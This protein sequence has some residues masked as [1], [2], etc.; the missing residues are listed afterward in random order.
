[1]SST[2]H[3]LR[4]GT[5]GSL[6]ARAQSQQVADALSLLHPGL[7]VDIV[8]I[9]TS[10]DAIVDRPLQELGGKGLFTK[11]LELALL[12][13]QIDFAVHSF[14][15]VPVTM[16]LI[17]TSELVIAAVPPRENPADVLVSLAAGS[18][19][20]LP[21]GS[22]VGTSSA[23]RRCQVLAIRPDVTVLPIR[24]NIDTRLG[25]LR[26]GEFD[27]ILLARA[28]VERAGLFDAAIMN[29][30]PEQQMLCAP[31]QGALALQC[32]RSDA[33]TR[34]L[35][36]AVEGPTTRLCV[37]AERAIVQGLQGDCHSPIAA[38]ATIQ[39]QRCTLHAR[40]GGR[41]GVPPV[42]SATATSSKDAPHVA[43]TR[44]LAELRSQGASRL[45][46]G[47]E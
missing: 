38:L 1:M 13:D 8:T 26:R 17:D 3:T 32:R 30:I 27:A 42:I 12:R 33:V 21:P 6:L 43:V 41:D 18:L 25:K 11:E 23:R 29:E 10:G 35:L 22:R 46:R 47:I 34:E 44:V 37:E 39:R 4:L 2:P 28:G 31:G 20:Q 45:L 36:A 9:T 5:R 19:E 7:R 14:K 16:P 15:D 24:G 40:V